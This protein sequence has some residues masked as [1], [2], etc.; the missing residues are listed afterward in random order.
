MAELTVEGDLLAAMFAA[1]RAD[2]D[3]VPFPEFPAHMPTQP[4]LRV[5]SP[6][7]PRVAA[8]SQWAT[9]VGA[10]IAAAGCFAAAA[11]LTVA[12]EL[13]ARL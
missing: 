13:G 7:F 1:L 12:S 8:A 2:V 5:V 6:R 11:V 3:S 4:T 10:A 9:T